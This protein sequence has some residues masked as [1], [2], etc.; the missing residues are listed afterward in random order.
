MAGTIETKVGAARGRGALAPEITLQ[1]V[2]SKD[3]N[4]CKEGILPKTKLANVFSLREAWRICRCRAHA[5]LSHPVRH[6]DKNIP[7][8]QGADSGQSAA[9]RRRLESRPPPSAGFVPSDAY[10]RATGQSRCEGRIPARQQ[11]RDVAVESAERDPPLH[12]F[13]SR[14]PETVR[15]D[16]YSIARDFD[17]SRCA[18]ICCCSDAIFCSAMSIASAPAKNRRGSW[19]CCVRVRRA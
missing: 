11:R 4:K 14:V 19:S 9:N 17:N 8:A 12:R 13:Q 7:P 3:R 1:R 15:G 10:H 2:F 5:Q 16:G 6:A 18:S